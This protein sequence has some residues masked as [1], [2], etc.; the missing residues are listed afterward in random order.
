M[1]KKYRVLRDQQEKANFWDFPESEYCVGTTTTNLKTGDYTLEHLVDK[2]SIERKYST[3]EIATNINEKRFERELDRLDK[4]DHS[5]I[6]CEFTMDDIFSFPAM[7]GIPSK[8]WPK[9]RVSS[10]FLIKRL[11]EIETSHK[12]KII[13]AGKH[14]SDYARRIFKRMNELYE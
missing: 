13:F 10:N 1:S 9:L 7:S 8:F 5:F 14:G 3:G 4:L 6:L 11:I 12:T 2:F